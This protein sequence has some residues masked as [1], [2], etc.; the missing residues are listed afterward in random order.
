MNLESSKFT[1]IY[2]KIYK[3][4]KWE[5]QLLCAQSNLLYLVLYNDIKDFYYIE[6]GTSDKDACYS[7]DFS[8]LP[9]LLKHFS[10]AASLTVKKDKM[11]VSNSDST[12]Q[13]VIVVKD[14]DFD[15]PEIGNGDQLDLNKEYLAVAGKFTGNDYPT[16]L[17]H[18][19]S[20]NGFFVT[21]S[22]KILSYNYKNLDISIEK[23]FA[24]LS[25]MINAPILITSKKDRIILND[26]GHLS[27][28]VYNTPDK[29]QPFLDIVGRPKDFV[30]VNKD[31]FIAAFS[32]HLINHGYL[33]VIVENDLLKMRS[34]SENSSALQTSFS[35]SG[36]IKVQ[37]K[38]KD[39]ENLI[40]LFSDTI[41]FGIHPSIQNIFCVFDDNFYFASI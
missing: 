4:K 16:N 27:S 1:T 25:A 32:P 7:G 6:V 15:F 8:S 30:S 24:Q 18:L 31:D 2:Q 10:G 40:P 23:H 22:S 39:I 12:I 34:H 3:A 41:K 5:K 9:S 13:F 14:E 35:N 36:D 33:N 26:D 17:I 19:D 37:F 20:D 11:M 38:I 28:A 21:D 29:I